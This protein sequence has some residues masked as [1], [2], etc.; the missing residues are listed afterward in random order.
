L[1]A[2]VHPTKGVS[3]APYG[4]V[5]DQRVTLLPD[6][7]RETWR[8]DSVLTWGNYDGSGEPITIS[9]REYFDSFVYAADY[10][11]APVSAVDEQI[12]TGNSLTNLPKVFPGSRFVEYHF[13]GFDQKYQGM[14]WRSLRL[15]FEER[16][17]G[18]WWLI[19]IV[20]DQ[21]TI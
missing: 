12:G 16:M 7:L 21:W 20:S 6:Q 15:V 4:F 5:A 1:A 17:G 19:A 2:N 10:A 11:K 3:F 8:A 13:P 18:R 14:D 9:I